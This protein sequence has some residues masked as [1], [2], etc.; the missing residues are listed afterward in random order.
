MAC[1]W[2]CV[3]CGVGLVVWGQRCV[4]GGVSCGVIDEVGRLGG[5]KVCWKLKKTGLGA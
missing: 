3:V 1:G 2:W 5:W 4:V